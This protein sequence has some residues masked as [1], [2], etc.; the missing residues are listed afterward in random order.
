MVELLQRMQSET[1]QLLVVVGLLVVGVDEGVIGLAALLIGFGE[2]CLAFLFLLFPGLV[3]PFFFD[4][5]VLDFFFFCKTLLLAG[6]VS[7]S[8]FRRILAFL[9]IWPPRVWRMF[10]RFDN[11]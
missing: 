4:F 3:S 9:L 11:W 10:S 5:F 7:S 6:A 1:L 2:S 8:S